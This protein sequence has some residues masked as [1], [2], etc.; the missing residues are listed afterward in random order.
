MIE[1]AFGWLI[2]FSL[3]MTTIEKNELYK[4]TKLL[5]REKL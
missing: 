4:K 2:L 3:I 5:A 1:G